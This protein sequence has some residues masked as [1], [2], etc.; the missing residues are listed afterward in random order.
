[1]ARARDAVEGGNEIRAKVAT[2]I[3]ACW[4]MGGEWRILR[5]KSGFMGQWPEILTG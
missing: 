5:F 2:E 4:L 1:M 3:V